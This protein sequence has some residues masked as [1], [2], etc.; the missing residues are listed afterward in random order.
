MQLKDYVQDLIDWKEIRVGA[1]PSP[2]VGL[3]MYQNTFPPHKTNQGKEPTNPPINK[4]NN[5]PGKQGDN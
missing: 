5:A 4:P 1:Q 3:M 2:S